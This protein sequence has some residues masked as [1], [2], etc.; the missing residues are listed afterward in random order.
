MKLI[1][2]LFSFV[3]LSAV[4]AVDIPMEFEEPEKQEQ[5]QILLEELRCLVCQNQSLADSNADLAQDLRT[6]VFNMVE[7][8]Q[9]NEVI[10]DFLVARYG[11]FVLYNPRL[12]P[13]TVLLWFG[14]FLLLIFAL[15]MAYRHVNRSKVEDVSITEEDRARAVELLKNTN[16]Q[17]NNT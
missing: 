1:T 9:A 15:F 10:I 6:Q 8:G 4:Y 12:N 13:V 11:D 2:L 14:P 5:Y 16:N 7:E 3:F 17:E